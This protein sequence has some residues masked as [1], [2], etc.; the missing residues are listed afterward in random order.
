M[1]GLLKVI[2]FIFTCLEVE[3]SCVMCNAL[4]RKKWR[5]SFWILQLGALYCIG[6]TYY[7]KFDSGMFSN[8]AWVVN[9]ALLCLILK[10]CY[11]ISFSAAISILTAFYAVMFSI[12]FF[13]LI[14]ICLLSNSE[15]FGINILNTCSWVRIVIFGILRSVDI[16]KKT[17]GLGNGV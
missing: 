5:F 8:T 2:E 7:N 17:K 14:V 6:T 4:F 9:I 15:T 10:I 11:Q 3:M 13:T 12:D 1:T 16:F